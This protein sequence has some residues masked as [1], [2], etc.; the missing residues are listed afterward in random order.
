MERYHHIEWFD[1]PKVQ[2][3]P[4]E[5]MTKILGGSGVL[6]VSTLLGWVRQNLIRFVHSVRGKGV[7]N[8]NQ[9]TQYS[10]A[11]W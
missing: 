7:F 3:N 2:Q 6:I 11:C 10:E 8:G 9:I 1:V 5:K 4:V